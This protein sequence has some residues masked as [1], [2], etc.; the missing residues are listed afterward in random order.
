MGGRGGEHDV[1]RSDGSIT[2]IKT[3]PSVWMAARDS[4][5]CHRGCV[6]AWFLRKQPHYSTTS[7]VWFNSVLHTLLLTKTPQEDS[8]LTEP[9][10]FSQ[11]HCGGASCP[12]LA[13]H[14]FPSQALPALLVLRQEAGSLPFPLNLGWLWRLAQPESYSGTSAPGPGAASG[15]LCGFLGKLTLEMLPQ[16]P[17]AMP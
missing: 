4:I 13:A 3:Q 10:H 12:Q 2:G 7:E 16:G 15:A 11:R 6:L 1:L 5:H 14:Y 9:T 17:A 8:A